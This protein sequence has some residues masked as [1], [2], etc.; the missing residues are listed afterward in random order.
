MSFLGNHFSSED[1]IA[2]LPMIKCRGSISTM[3]VIKVASPEL[4]DMPNWEYSEEV[5][6]S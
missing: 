3:D 5:D 2:E 6:H 1:G 4:S